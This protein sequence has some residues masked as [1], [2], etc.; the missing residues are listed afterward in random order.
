[1]L[2]YPV[3]Q[4]VNVS[5]TSYLLRR[6][7]LLT[8]QDMIRLWAWFL[9]GK[10]GDDANFVASLYANNQTTSRMRTQLAKLFDFEDDY[11]VVT[12]TQRVEAAT[13]REMEPKECDPNGDAA[14]ESYVLPVALHEEV[15]PMLAKSL[16][17]LPPAYFTTCEF[18]VLR[19]EALLYVKRMQNAKP[20]IRVEHRHYNQQHGS[21]GTTMISDLADY[22]RNNPKFF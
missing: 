14:V 1:M 4:F 22:L 8:K 20:P 5:T 16:E 17:D 10:R 3:L 15:S 2:I 7:Q 11:S 19:D 13:I 6:Y 18:D 21:M 12:V 9:F